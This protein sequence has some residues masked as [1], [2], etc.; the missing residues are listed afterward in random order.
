MLS[1]SIIVA[2]KSLGDKGQNGYINGST[3][4]VFINTF[5]ECALVS[6]IGD[7]VSD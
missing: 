7:S 4:K 3:S 5:T 6:L 2:N 1:H